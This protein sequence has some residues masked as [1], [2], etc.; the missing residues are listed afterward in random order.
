MAL[1]QNVGKAQMSEYRIQNLKAYGLH[2]F[3]KREQLIKTRWGK[4]V[5][6]GVKW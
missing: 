6:I 4:V 5:K 3:E 2:A 1:Y